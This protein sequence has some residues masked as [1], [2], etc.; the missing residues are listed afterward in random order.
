MTLPEIATRM[1]YPIASCLLPH[2]LP[3]QSVLISEQLHRQ[4][5]VRRLKERDDLVTQEIA[6]RRGHA[7]LVFETPFLG[8][9]Q[10]FLRG[11]V[12]ARLIAEVGRA[13][14][15]SRPMKEGVVAATQL[16]IRVRSY[17][18]RRTA[19][20]LKSRRRAHNGLA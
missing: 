8:R 14:E 1:Y 3:H 11:S 19:A 16:L 18:D 15:G 6:G 20:I 10:L 17:R 2:L 4:F 7:L 12:E 5:I 13:V 9:R